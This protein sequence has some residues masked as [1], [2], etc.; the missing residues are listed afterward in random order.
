MLAPVVA[1]T[2]ITTWVALMSSWAKAGQLE[3]PVPTAATSRA[4]ANPLRHGFMASN[5]PCDSDATHKMTRRIRS[6]QA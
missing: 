3:E 4:G 5:G 6:W 2:P 1:A